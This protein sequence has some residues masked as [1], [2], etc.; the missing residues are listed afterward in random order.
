MTEVKAT[1]IKGGVHRAIWLAIL[2]AFGFLS[3]GGYSVYRWWDYSRGNGEIDFYGR[4]VDERGEPVAGVMVQIEVR[5]NPLIPPLI[6]DRGSGCFKRV[7]R[8]TGAD[9]NFSVEGE[10]GDVLMV[11]HF[12]LGAQY[13]G[14][15]LY[16]PYM[17]PRKWNFYY[18]DKR[19]ESEPLP[20]E[21]HPVVYTVI[22]PSGFGHK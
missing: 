13:L 17:P 7:D 20:D 19:T 11:E 9:G 5:F 18:G 4:L 3:V 16:K 12:K 6:Q 10:D 21:N 2:F 1:P 22:C 8:V 15:P 14:V